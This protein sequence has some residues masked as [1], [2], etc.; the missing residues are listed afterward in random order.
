MKGSV[1][2]VECVVAGA[3][4]RRKGS[5]SGEEGV[6]EG[7]KEVGGGVRW[8][9]KDVGG[10]GQCVCVLVC[11]WDGLDRSGEGQ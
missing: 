11:V 7:R 8:Q 1:S 2:V 10:E 4:G 3:G 9:G 6:V 5:V